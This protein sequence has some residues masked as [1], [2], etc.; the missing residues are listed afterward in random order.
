MASSIDTVQKWTQALTDVTCLSR[1]IVTALQ[2]AQD[3]EQGDIVTEELNNKLKYNKDKAEKAKLQLEK[4]IV[5]LHKPLSHLQLSTDTQPVQATDD[6]ETVLKQLS[7]DTQPV[8][9][10]DEAVLKRK[11]P[12]RK[13]KQA[14]KM[15]F[16]ERGKGH[17]QI[18]VLFLISSSFIKMMFFV[19]K[20]K[21][22]W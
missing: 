2:N 15:N 17:F 5:E 16:I 8:Q 19:L 7:T 20:T 14:I 3:T 22:K 6:H 4:V 13:Y 18:I 1:N 10:T 12:G 21:I 11:T 9:A